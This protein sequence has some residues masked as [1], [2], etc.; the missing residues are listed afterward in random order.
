M[1]VLLRFLAT[2]AQY[3]DDSRIGNATGS[4]SDC[5]GGNK[6]DSQN[7][8][9]VIAPNILYSNVEDL[10]AS[11]GTQNLAEREIEERLDSI[12]VVR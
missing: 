6:M 8:A 9:T 7:L 11:S 5:V 3:S 1:Y 10:I 12:N 2:V 4:N